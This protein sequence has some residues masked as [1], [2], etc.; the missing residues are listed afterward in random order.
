MVATRFDSSDASH[1]FLIRPNR[2]LSWRG[3]L[4]FY[5]GIVLVSFTIAGG[6]ALFGA[7][8]VLPFAGLEMLVLGAA[9][10]V[11]A[12]RASC[13]QRIHVQG[14]AV[15]VVERRPEG[16]QR[17]SF[18]R[19]WARVE[20]TKSVISGYPVRLF[21]RSHGKSMEIGGCLNDHEKRQLAARLR[22]AVDA[23]PWPVA[24]G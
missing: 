11:V 13:W 2:S 23:D 16:E 14:D 12:R 3:V 5:L 15:E 19:A 9:L 4:R 17:R 21:I 1:R 7:W 22:A 10:Y 20:L 8:P 18:Q 24:R 6:F